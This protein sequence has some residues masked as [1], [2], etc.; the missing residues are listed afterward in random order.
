MKPTIYHYT[1]TLNYLAD[2]YRE[3]R[4]SSDISLKNWSEG[5]GF[6]SPVLLVDFL[7]KK[8]PIKL[9]HA[10]IL[11]KGLGLNERETL[12]FK[13]LIQYEKSTEESKEYYNNILSALRP[14]DTFVDQDSGI[15][16]HW[17]NVVIFTMAQIHNSPMTLQEIQQGLKLQ[18]STKTIKDSLNILLT[19]GLLILTEENKYTLGKNYSLQ[20]PND[21]L[22]KSTH[23]YYEQ[24][25]S[26]AQEAIQFDVNE[27]EFQCFAMGMKKE[28]LS[29]AKEIIRKARKDI[30]ELS[31]DQANQVY[32]F[33]FNSFPMTEIR[34]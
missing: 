7:K 26:K 31:T 27:R 22:I 9:K 17:L 25:L 3:L 23:T 20:T 10:D 28:D 6:E 2:F 8:R 32:Q 29:K 16:S 21:V 19:H 4:E 15:F 14:I 24:I 34:L 1:N 12:Y 13:T 11:S 5:M 30:G 18:V 33:N